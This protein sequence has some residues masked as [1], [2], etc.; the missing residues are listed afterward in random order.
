M[1]SYTLQQEGVFEA[2]ITSAEIFD[3]DSGAK[4]INLEL[5][6]VREY[7]KSAGAYSEPWPAG[8][9]FPGSVWFVKKT[10]EINSDAVKSFARATGWTG[11]VRQLGPVV[12]VLVKCTVK[13]EEYNGNVSYRAAFINPAGEADTQALASA[14]GASLMALAAEVGPVQPKRYTPPA[15]QPATA[16]APPPLS[17]EITEPDPNDKVPF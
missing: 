14:Y 8:W 15:G 12:N 7:D 13:R 16:I 1:S 4:A 9:T 3:A 17:P 11:D 6:V 5:E 10:G 2:R